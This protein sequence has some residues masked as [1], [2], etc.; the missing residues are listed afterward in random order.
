MILMPGIWLWISV[1][2]NMPTCTPLSLQGS[3]PAWVC[4]KEPSDLLSVFFKHLSV[5]KTGVKQ[6]STW[7]KLTS[8]T[9]TM[10]TENKQDMK[11]YSIS[12][13]TA[14][15]L[16]LQHLKLNKSAGKGCSALN[17]SHLSIVV[18]SSFFYFLP[19][20]Q[21]FWT[22]FPFFSSSFWS[23][24]SWDPSWWTCLEGRFLLSKPDS[25]V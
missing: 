16:T 21:M 19:Q 14:H 8:L 25:W 9:A 18:F 15:C 13:M 7:H 3:E 24:A 5:S 1:C 22:V 4:E 12:V 2:L 23:P 17:N 11:T 20:L 10:T 6:T